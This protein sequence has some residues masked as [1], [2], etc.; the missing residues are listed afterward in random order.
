LAVNVFVVN[1]AVAPADRVIVGVGAV[2]NVPLITAAVAS[3]VIDVV[4]YPANVPV[5]VTVIG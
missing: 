4:T 3:L 2:P 1:G 5:T